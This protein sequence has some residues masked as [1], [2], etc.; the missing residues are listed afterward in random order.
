MKN[1]RILPLVL[2]LSVILNS[3]AFH[4]GYM[5]NSASLGQAN[6]DYVSTSITGSSSTV[7]LFGLGGIAKNA[8]VEDAKK[9]MLEQNPLKSNQAIANLTV[10]WKNGFYFFIMTTKCTVTADIVEFKE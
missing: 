5:I 1:L 3:C 9:K 4:N 6:F 7:K 2:F 8:L 10:N